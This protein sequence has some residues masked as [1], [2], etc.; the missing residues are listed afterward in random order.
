MAGFF[1]LTNGKKTWYYLRK[2]GIK[3]ACLAVWERLEERKQPPYRF[4]AP[5]AE[6]LKKQQQSAKQ[7]A[8][9]VRFSVLVPAYETKPEYLTA[10]LNSVYAQ[11]YPYWELVLADAGNTALVY[12]TLNDWAKDKNVLLLEENAGQSAD[13]IFRAGSVRYLKLSENGGISANTNAG[14]EI[15]CGDYTGLLDHDDLL[16]ADA[17]FEMAAAIIREKE[18]GK[19]PQVLYSDEDKCDGSGAFFYEPHRKTDFDPELLLTNNYICHFLVMK[20]K[21]LR[22]LKL[23]SAF[24]GAQDFDLVLRAYLAGNDFVH[25]PR[26]LY[27]WRCHEESTASNPRSKAYAYEAGKRAVEEF[28]R[29]KGWQVTVTDTEHLGFY[30]ISYADLWRDRPEIGAVAYPVCKKGRM[31]SGIYERDGQFRFQ[32]L[33]A[34]FSGYIHRAVLQQSAETADVRQMRVRPELEQERRNAVKKCGI[35]NP[36][37]ASQEFAGLLSDRGQRV[38]WDPKGK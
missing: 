6:L 15:A 3:S 28:C 2:N 14:L 36:R 10:L 32:G 13:R 21:L 5:T 26:V 17:L 11:S 30:R 1:S 34:G 12:E 23:R 37:T 22:A 20:T 35:M 27:H 18:N 29:Q 25:V 19:E 24:D 8:D 4:A 38:L 33:R 7:F 9:P 31:C 16:T